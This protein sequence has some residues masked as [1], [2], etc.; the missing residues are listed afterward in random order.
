MDVELACEAAVAGI[1]CWSVYNSDHGTNSNWDI[2]LPLSEVYENILECL[3]S[4]R[5]RQHGRAGTV[6]VQRRLHHVTARWGLLI[7]APQ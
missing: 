2:F 4:A 5:V 6:L 7:R 1:S 3:I